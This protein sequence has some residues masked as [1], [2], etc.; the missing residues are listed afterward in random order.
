MK[1]VR[2][3][4]VR[5]GR[6]YP[7]ETFLCL[8]SVRGWVNSR[9]MVRSEGLCQWKI[10]MTPSG[11]EPETFRLV[12]QCLNQLRYRVPLSDRSNQTYLHAARNLTCICL[13]L[14]GRNDVIRSCQHEACALFHS[15][16]TGN[17]KSNHAFNYCCDSFAVKS[18]LI[19]FCFYRI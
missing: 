11:I 8:I 10:P 4:A 12:A 1:V 9:A 18:T 13:Y 15:F 19:D 14:D 3:W 5:T 2:L 17:G 6:L 16:Y 7:Q